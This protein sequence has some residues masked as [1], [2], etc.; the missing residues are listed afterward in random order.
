MFDLDHA[1]WSSILDCGA[2]PSSFTAEIREKTEAVAVDPAYQASV[3]ELRARSEATVE[4]LA[5]RFANIEGRFVWD[6]YENLDDRI[7][8]LER[9]HERFFADFG[10]A[11]GRY[12]AAALPH[13][14]FR[15]DSFDL[16]LVAHLLFMYDRW[17]NEEFHRKAI[18]E[19]CRVARTE[20]RVYPLFSIDG[21]RSKFV[22]PVV[23]WLEDVGHH[24]ERRTVPF[25]FQQGANEVLVVNP[26]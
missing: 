21:T 14:P 17:M 3:S 5:S 12:I 6:F 13:L 23:T 10:S 7:S 19:L 4:R 18:G 26:A 16:A 20:V 2:G 22:D 25:E 1:T 9:A 15:T 11:P 24:V 8:Y